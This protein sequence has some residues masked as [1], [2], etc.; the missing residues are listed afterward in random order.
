VSKFTFLHKSH[1]GQPIAHDP[2]WTD[3]RF[4]AGG[5]PRKRFYC[6]RDGQLTATLYLPLAFQATGPA[7]VRVRLVREATR[8]QPMDPTGYDE[9]ALIAESDGY[10]RVRFVYEGQAEKGRR[11]RWQAQ[12]IGSATAEA[13]GTHYAEFWRR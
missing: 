8:T 12:I 9:R 1:R 7:L 10:A 5:I 2:E 13:T 11:Y 4:V 6:D 3:L